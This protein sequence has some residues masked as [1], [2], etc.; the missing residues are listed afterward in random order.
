MK[1]NI[2]DLLDEIMEDDL[3]LQD[4]TPLSARRIKSKTLAS[5]PK[6]RTITLR[7]LPKA[8]VIAAVIVALSASVYA[9]DAVFNDGEVF[10][11]F[12]DHLFF[13]N[14]ASSGFDQSPTQKPT[15]TIPPFTGSQEELIDDMDRNFAESVTSNGTTITPIRAIA[16]EN[17]YYLYLRVQTPEGVS[18]PDMTEEYYYSFDGRGHEKHRLDLYYCENAGSDAARWEPAWILNWARPLEDENPEDNA[19]EFVL[20]LSTNTN[21]LQLNGPHPKKLIIRNLHIIKKYDPLGDVELFSGEVVLDITLYNEN[22]EGQSLVLRPDDL[23][24]YNEGY[25][26]TTTVK[27]IIITSLAIEMDISYTQ[28]NNKYI[29]P[30]GGPVQLVMKD[31]RVID[32]LEAYYNAQEH[33]Y[34]HPD[35]IV[36]VVSK[37][38]FNE[39]IVVG[40]IDYLLFNGEI[41]VDVN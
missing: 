7:W 12:S 23:T 20:Q 28:P 37:N 35:S 1:Y 25:D 14:T 22:S 24:F 15:E 4:R 2:S 34:P 10:E 31:G 36:G 29:F 16:D 18:L 41:I 40:E 11:K 3:T 21:G 8:A 13:S 39:P 32:A 38:K 6:K 27:K 17:N 33:W 19:K 5:F 9:V 26:Y 30:Y